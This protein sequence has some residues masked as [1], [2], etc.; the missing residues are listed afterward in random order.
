MNNYNDKLY[1]KEVRT[2]DK[3]IQE[4]FHITQNNLQFSVEKFGQIVEKCL[5]IYYQEE[6][7]KIQKVYN[8]NNN[9]IIEEKLKEE[10]RA[11]NEIL[12]S[13]NNNIKKEL[14]E[15][16]TNDLKIIEDNINNLFNENLSGRD[17]IILRDIK[18]NEYSCSSIK[19]KL[20]ENIKKFEETFKIYLLKKVKYQ[21]E[22]EIYNY[23]QQQKTEQSEDIQNK[24]DNINNYLNNF[25]INKNEDYDKL[26]S[27]YKILKDYNNNK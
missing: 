27:L 14:E 9:N 12:I 1:G 19:E 10:Q 15:I 5:K 21:E 23:R 11:T 7:E 13:F 18:N 20:N 16:F 17:R 2:R 6:K 3:L 22:L 24:Y 26:K 25:K 8:E 4:I